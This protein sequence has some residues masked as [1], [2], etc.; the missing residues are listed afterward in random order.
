MDGRALFAQS[1]RGGNP[2][3]AGLVA[4]DTTLLALDANEHGP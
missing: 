2:Q 1:A 3:A 4:G